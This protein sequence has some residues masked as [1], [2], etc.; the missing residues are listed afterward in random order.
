MRQALTTHEL[1]QLGYLLAIP[2]QICH[3][4]LLVLIHGVVSRPQVLMRHFGKMSQRH[5][6]VILAPDFSSPNFRKFQKLE[7]G[8]EIDGAAQQ[9]ERVAL[10]TAR[11]F[12]LYEQQIDLAGYSAGAQFAHRFA[13]TRPSAVRRLLIGAAGWYTEADLELPWPKGLGDQVG[14][15]TLREFL[16]LPIKIAVGEFDRQSDSSLR[17]NPELDNRQGRNRRER[18][19]F[20]KTHL[21]QVGQ[22]NGIEAKVTVSELPAT[23][24]SLKEAVIR[25]RIDRLLA[26]HILYP[27]DNGAIR[28]AIRDQKMPIYV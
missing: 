28:N 6:I 5:G 10:Q 24:H 1:P 3:P 9:L 2:P 27:D 23:G 22:A 19:H 14:E 25:G 17:R 13:M 8:G 11:R 16:Q 12:G 4:Y 7:A 21:Q 20:W 26:D 15:T 18:A